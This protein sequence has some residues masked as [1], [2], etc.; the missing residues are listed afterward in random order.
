MFDLDTLVSS[1]NIRQKLQIITFI[2]FFDFI[3]VIGG[4]RLVFHPADIVGRMT[5]IRSQVLR[6]VK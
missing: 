2:E 4:K 1:L 6:F 5:L 3:P